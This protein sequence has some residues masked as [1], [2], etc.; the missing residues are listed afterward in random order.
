MTNE[1]ILEQQIEALEKLLQLRK[2][3]I[4]ELESKLA[5]VQAEKNAL[6]YPW[7]GGSGGLG[8]SSPPYHQ[9]MYP[10]IG[11]GGTS[12]IQI[13]LCPDGTPHQ[14]PSSWGHSTATPCCTKCGCPMFGAGNVT[15][16]A[17]AMG[18]G[19]VTLTNGAGLCN[20]LSADGISQANNVITLASAAK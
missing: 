5:K 9:P 4:D 17:G 13:N 16:Q 7:L 19:H 3:V 12:T 15:T 11:G 20:T 10:G 6:Q 2:A 8:I 18:G 14:Y 1:E